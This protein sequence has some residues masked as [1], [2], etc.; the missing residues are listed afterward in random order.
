MAEDYKKGT[1]DV[2]DFC[3]EKIS[4]N[5][6]LFRNTQIYKNDQILFKNIF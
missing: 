3:D 1:F 5:L 6:F 4:N 2:K